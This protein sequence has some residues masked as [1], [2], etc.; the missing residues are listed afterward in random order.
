MKL[1]FNKYK[2]QEKEE[3]KKLSSYFYYKILSE[4]T[5]KRQNTIRQWFNR[6]KIDVKISEN[7][8]DYLN[9]NY[10]KNV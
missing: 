3:I 10:L 6:N 5:W 9:K 7:F 8:R 1:R 4:L 2:M